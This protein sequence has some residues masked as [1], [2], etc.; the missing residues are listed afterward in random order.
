[1]ERLPDLWLFIPWGDNVKNQCHVSGKKG[2]AQG[3]EDY[4]FPNKKIKNQKIKH[5]FA[6]SVAS[7]R[8][9]SKHMMRRNL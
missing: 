6:T 4:H 3:E 7:R 9:F 5:G 8:T 2:V 1:M